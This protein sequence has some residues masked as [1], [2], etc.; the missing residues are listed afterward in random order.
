MAV[1][2]GGNTVVINCRVLVRSLC[3]N[4]HFPRARSCATLPG[5]HTGGRA[6]VSN[7]R[8]LAAV[9]LGYTER[10]SVATLTAN[11][12]KLITPMFFFCN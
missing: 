2:H 1:P 10:A 9:G 6:I 3:H 11:R 7:G 8:S 4:P 12:I 5:K